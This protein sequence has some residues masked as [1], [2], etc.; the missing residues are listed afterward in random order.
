MGPDKSIEAEVALENNIADD[1]ENIRYRKPY[2]R[3]YHEWWVK[4]MLTHVEREGSI[5]DNGCGNGILFAMLNR[6]SAFGLDIS[7]NM[8]ERARCRN[9]KVVLGDSHC[10]PFCSDKF[11]AIF[12]KGL[13]HHLHDPLQGIAEMHRVLKRNGEAVLV[14]T[15]QS[16]FSRIP[17]MLAKKGRHFSHHHVNFD[18]NRYIRLIKSK[19]AVEEVV[20]FGYVAYPLLGFPDVIDVFRFL[21]L[22]SML[23]RLLIRLDELISRIPFFNMQSWAILVKA[24][25]TKA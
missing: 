1:Y 3:L 15:N 18:H 19:F 17:R 4:K 7:W 16:V 2:S 23:Y 24:R 8:L 9:P 25:K 20:F 6:N 11:D 5:L 21:P 12:C 14:D 10:L 13:L 22:Q